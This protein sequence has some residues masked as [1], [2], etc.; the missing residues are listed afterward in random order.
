MGYTIKPVS[1]KYLKASENQIHENSTKALKAIDH[2]Y[3]LGRI[4]SAIMFV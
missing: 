3:D 2:A 1:F 4:F